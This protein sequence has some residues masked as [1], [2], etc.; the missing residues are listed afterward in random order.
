MWDKNLIKRKV[1]ELKKNPRRLRT[2]IGNHRKKHSL[3]NQYNA[4][5]EKYIKDEKKN[6]KSAEK[7]FL[8]RFNS[9][10]G[11]K[12]ELGIS[13]NS[14]IL[15]ELF[16]NFK[17]GKSLSKSIKKSL[18]VN[19]KELKHL[20]NKSNDEIIKGIEAYLNKKLIKFK[21][22]K[23][24]LSVIFNK[25]NDNE[26]FLKSEDIAEEI[27]YLSSRLIDNQKQLV[28]TSKKLSHER[29]NKLESLK[30]YAL[31]YIKNEKNTELSELVNKNY[32]LCC[33][34]IKENLEEK[35]NR[36]TKNTSLISIFIRSLGSGDF[37]Q[38]LTTD[39]KNLSHE[40]N[41][42]VEKRD[43]KF[44]N[45]YKANRDDINKVDKLGITPLENCGEK[46]YNGLSEKIDRITNEIIGYMDKKI[47]ESKN[48]ISSL[49]NSK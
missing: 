20:E 36:E 4:E 18:E 24:C 1:T 9:V 25:C 47:S 15:E 37:S 16:K 22:V 6:I 27:R 43:A 26:N 8:S 29:D 46:I 39:C 45:N 48:K 10:N 23:E 3:I 49:K 32:K 42:K 28:D 17:S 2:M 14:K 31:D 30:E 40:I 35:F 13:E 7:N 12:G 34:S 21:A 41:K 33:D 19:E 38:I 44:L 5:I 11:L